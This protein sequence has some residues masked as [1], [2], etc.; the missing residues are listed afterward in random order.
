MRDRRA[1]LEVQKQKEVEIVEKILS[2]EKALASRK[3]RHPHLF[4]DRHKEI[5]KV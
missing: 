5:V 2:E 4:V 3:K 1:K